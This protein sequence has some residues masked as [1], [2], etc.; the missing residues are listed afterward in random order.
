MVERNYN[1]PDSV[2]FGLGSGAGFALA[3]IALATALL[4][5]AAARNRSDRRSGN[6][7]CKI[8]LLDNSDSKAGDKDRYDDRLYLMDRDGRVEAALSGFNIQV[9]G[10][11]FVQNHAE[12]T[13]GG[14]QADRNAKRQGP[15][16][17]AVAGRDTR[18]NG[19]GCI[20]EA[21]LHQG[22]DLIQVGGAGGADP[23]AGGRLAAL[24]G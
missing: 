8:L 4:P 12:F 13:G 3:I 1:F 6:G 10:A 22:V 23:V 14:V 9:N 15:I 18:N 5:M 7:E 20:R 17:P 16:A 24:L 2:V 19:K 21:L 11:T